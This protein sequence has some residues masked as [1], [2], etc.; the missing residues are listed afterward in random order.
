MLHISELSFM[1]IY[2][3]GY[4]ISCWVLPYINIIR[5]FVVAMPYD[6]ARE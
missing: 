3:L 5:I 2:P 4:I 1:G 6:Y